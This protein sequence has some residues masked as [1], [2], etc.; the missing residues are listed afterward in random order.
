MNKLFNIK[1]SLASFS[2]FLLLP[3]VPAFA[4][5]LP[6]EISDSNTQVHFEVDSTW[7]TVHGKVSKITGKSWLS[8]PNDLSSVNA[9]IHFPI[10]NFDTD[11][12]SR[13]KKMR[14]VMAADKFPDVVL[15]LH[16][17][18]PTRICLPNQVSET[19]GC[20]SLLLGSLSIHGITRELK[21]G[22]KITK[23]QDGYS[24]SGSLPFEWASFGVEDPSILIAKLDPTVTVFFETHLAALKG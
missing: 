2:L 20:E 21:L 9:E 11:N 8:N 19:N 10:I 14:E 6:N 15:N 4:W 22:V 7:H 18:D 13:D 3:C 1:N 12:S 23:E 17:M 16:G 24:V 5:N